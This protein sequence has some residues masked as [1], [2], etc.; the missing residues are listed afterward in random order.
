MKTSTIALSALLITV[1]TFSALLWIQ[2]KESREL[3][4][5]LRARELVVGGNGTPQENLSQGSNAAPAIIQA[6]VDAGLCPE[7]LT[8]PTLSNEFISRLEALS[9]KQRSILSGLPEERFLLR[10][11]EYRKARLTQI[12]LSIAQGYPGIDVALGLPEEEVDRMFEV[13]ADA[14]LAVLTEMELGEAA[15]TAEALMTLVKRQEAAQEDTLRASLGSVRYSQLTEYRHKI[16]PA[17]MQVSNISNTLTSSGYPLSESQTQSLRTAL[18]NDVQNQLYQTVAP[19]GSLGSGTKRT[20][21][22]ALGDLPRRMEENN[23]RILDASTPYLSDA[24]IQVLREQYARQASAIRDTVQN[25][26]GR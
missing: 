25:A 13:M 26:I 16:Q 10:D 17:L 7:P 20:S 1:I 21:A 23:K 4:A 8:E 11:P 3:I 22:Q 15:T 2:N 6:A 18:V 19:G 12:R 14:Q 24:Q 9:S 5:S